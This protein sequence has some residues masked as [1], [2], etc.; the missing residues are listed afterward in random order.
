MART[1]KQFNTN[2]N[3]VQRKVTMYDR[4]SILDV[5]GNMVEAEL[6]HIATGVDL[7]A[8]PAKPVKDFLIRTRLEV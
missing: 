1:V 4:I 8:S 2:V 5:Y 7:H 3:G 6:Q